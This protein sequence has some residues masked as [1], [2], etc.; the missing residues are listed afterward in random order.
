[1]QN[2]AQICLVILTSNVTNISVQW[3]SD[4]LTQLRKSYEVEVSTSSKRSTSDMEDGDTRQVVVMKKRRETSASPPPPPPP[5]SSS[6][7][8]YPDYYESPPASQAVPWEKYDDDD[9]DDDADDDDFKFSPASPP[10]T[11]TTERE[12]RSSP[13]MV[14]ILPNASIVLSEDDATYIPD[15]PANPE[16]STSDNTDMSQQVCDILIEEGVGNLIVHRLRRSQLSLDEATKMTCQDITAMMLSP[17]W[18]NELKDH[19]KATNSE[20]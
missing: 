7:S 3:I 8:A 4:G 11:Q 5:P 10:L 1:M 2:D 9:D 19:I 17:E 16:P 14:Y 6:S 12:E 18:Q 13:P 15:H 20:L